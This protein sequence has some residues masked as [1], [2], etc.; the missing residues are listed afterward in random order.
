[1]TEFCIYVRI[2]H[3]NARLLPRAACTI[4]ALR[5]SASRR[6]SDSVLHRMAELWVYSPISR[7]IVCLWCSSQG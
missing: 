4:C 2:S 3:T 7:V 1:M 6:S 5:I